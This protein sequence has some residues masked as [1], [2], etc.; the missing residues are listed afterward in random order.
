MKL[1]PNNDKQHGKP[2]SSVKSKTHSLHDFERKQIESKDPIGQAV[3]KDERIFFTVYCG[4]NSL[5]LKIN[6]PLLIASPNPLHLVEWKPLGG[7]QVIGDCA[8]D[9]EGLPKRN[10]QERKKRG[11]GGGRPPLCQDISV[12]L[13]SWLAAY[14]DIPN[15]VSVFLPKRAR[16]D[17]FKKHVHANRSRIPKTDNRSFVPRPSLPP[18]WET[19]DETEG[20]KGRC[21]T[22]LQLVERS[23]VIAKR[24]GSPRLDIETTDWIVNH[25]GDFFWIN[26]LQSIRER[27]RMTDFKILKVL[28]DIQQESG[29]PFKHF[30]DDRYLL[31]NKE[32]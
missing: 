24:L 27:V 15:N 20:W 26:P 22:V 14:C 13:A 21:P 17:S 8:N 11:S 2:S 10:K 23:E 3:S 32:Y 30:P 25:L 16:W 31:L 12:R 7:V 5:E 6:L 18:V 4:F 19:Y 29:T 9:E 28:E 1:R